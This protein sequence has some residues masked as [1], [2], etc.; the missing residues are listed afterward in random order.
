MSN[1]KRAIAELT[2]DDR[3]L[4]RGLARAEKRFSSL[5]RMGGRAF[6]SLGSVAAGALGGLLG[7]GALGGTALIASEAA[8]TI[9]FEES[10]T[11]LGINAGAAVG[12]LADVRRRVFDISSATGVARE[13]VLQAA[14][15][16]VALTGDGAAAAASMELFAKISKGT[17]SSMEDIAASAAAM[18][19]NLRIDPAQFEKAF[20][21]LIKGGK[22]GSVELRDLASLLAGLSPQAAR[23]K[24]GVG[25]EGLADLAAALQ[26]TRQGFGSANEAATGLESLMSS[27]AQHAGRFEDAGIQVFDIS[28]DGTKTLKS[29]PDIVNAI[30]SS[31]LMKDPTALQ[32]AFGRTEAMRAFEQLV[33]VRGAWRD[34]SAETMAANDVAEDYA[35][36]QQS[37]A[38]RIQGAW[39]QVKNEVAAALT[40]E[41]IEAFAAALRGAVGWIQD[42][43]RGLNAVGEKLAELAGGDDAQI[44]QM[45][46]DD[47]LDNALLKGMSMDEIERLATKKVNPY[48]PSDVMG[49]ARLIEASGSA[50]F[51]GIQKAIGRRRARD[52]RIAKQDADRFRKSPSLLEREAAANSHQTDMEREARELQIEVVPSAEFDTIVSERQA[53]SPRQRR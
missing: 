12:S 23:F 40:P 44:T 18:Q 41:R 11:R 51:E 53:N 9:K 1:R 26:I 24:G 52:R 42:M 3:G 4:Q 10:L 7:G 17:G 30:A 20:S 2:A 27:I 16:F 46:Q 6:K 8:K 43:V 38:G 15:S 21:I 14:A 13:D 37:S 49:Q 31:K 50:D 47:A 29:L 32:K 39:N 5:S 19:Q 25:T 34:L 45:G 28:A 36:F 22:A 33:K 35:T 48:N